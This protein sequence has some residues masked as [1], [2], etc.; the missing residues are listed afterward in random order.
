MLVVTA[1]A[2]SVLGLG[3]G[4][5]HAESSQ[6]TNY[7]V[8]EVQF[9]IGGAQNLCS[10]SYC[11]SQSAGDTVVGNSRSNSYGMYG[12]FNTSDQPYLEVWAE[13]GSYNLGTL[14]PDTTATATTELKV[15]TYL[16]GGY[17]MQ[18]TGTPLSQGTHTMTGITTPSTSQPG[19]EQ[20]GINLVNNSAPDIGTDPVHVPSSEFS[21][22]EPADDY[23]TA[24]L[25]KYVNGD[26]VAESDRSSGETHYTISM[27][28]NVSNVTPGGKYTGSYSAVVVPVF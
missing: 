2:A 17:V 25:Y 20:F 15:R 5:A 1:V 3:I 22:G 24:D 6:S 27:I 13:G 28:V 8:N 19:A 26:I 14:S 11:S 23:G 10:D 16:A 18:I 7:K 9:G 12:G 4:A 21:F